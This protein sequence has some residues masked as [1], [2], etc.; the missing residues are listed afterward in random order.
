MKRVNVPFHIIS[1][2]SEELKRV[3]KVL[4]SGWWTTG[5]KVREFEGKFAKYTGAKYAVAV[6]SCTAALHLSLLAG[7]IGPGDEIILPA[8]TFSATAQAVLYSGAR[9]V[10]V[11]IERDTGL[12]DCGEVEKKINKKTKAI[13]SVDYSGQPADYSELKK[14][15]RKNKL[16]YVSDA[17]HDL[18]TYYKKEIVGSQANLSCFSFYATKTIAAGE[19]GMVVTNNQK[20]AE[21]ISQLRLHGMNRNAWKRYGQGGSWYYEI[22]DLGYKYNLTDISAALGLVQLKKNQALWQKRSKIARRY[23]QAFSRIPE[24][25]VPKIKPDRQTSWHLYVLK[26]NLERLKIGRNK[27]IEELLKLG[28]G[29]S[30]HFIPLYRHPYYKKLLKYK[31]TEFPSSEWLYHRIISLPIF[32]EMSKKQ[33]N[34][35][36]ESISKI[37]KKYQR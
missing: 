15:C 9:P 8:M 32:P 19:G 36:I 28:V 6:S 17:A 7:K 23:N 21:K 10:F 33:I 1:V 31:Y 37:I 20:L 13:I 2:G 27:F 29:T 24:V 25:I 14:I 22:I 5:P 16:L 26:L 30:V 34:H 4:K 3:S 35:V 18:P 11:D 12:I